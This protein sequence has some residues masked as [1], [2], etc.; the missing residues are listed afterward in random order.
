MP[1]RDRRTHRLRD[2]ARPLWHPDAGYDDAALFAPMPAHVF[3]SFSAPRTALG[4]GADRRPDRAA[5]GQ[6]HAV[7]VGGVAGAGRVLR[8]VRPVP[9][10]LHQPRADWRRHF[11]QWR[12]RGV[13]H[14]RSGRIRGGHLP[15]AVC[16]CRAIEPVCR[17]VRASPGVYL[18][19]DLVHRGDRGDGSAEHCQRCDRAALCGRYRVGNRTGHHR[20]VSVRTGTAA[21]AQC[22]V[23]ICIF[24]AISGG[25]H[26]RADRMDGCRPRRWG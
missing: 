13:R 18:R 12:G 6:R 7:A 21:H 1:S 4:F 8:V 5:A 2:E 10:R 16:R 24:R 14:V 19:L 23:C 3:E 11:C 20:Y 17:P 26:V 15:W 22:G 25:P 9:D